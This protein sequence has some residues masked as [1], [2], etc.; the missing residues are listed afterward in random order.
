M[1]LKVNRSRAVTA[2]V[3]AGTGSLPVC[4]H[5]LAKAVVSLDTWLDIVVHSGG[6][7]ERVVDKSAERSGG[8]NEEG[9]VVICTPWKWKSEKYQT[10]GCWVGL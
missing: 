1:K 10:P 4:V 5:V 8:L 3:R 7:V 9:Y 2:L 6:N